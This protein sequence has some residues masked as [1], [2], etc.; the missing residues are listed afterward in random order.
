MVFSNAAARTAAI[1]SPVEGQMTYLEDTDQ[2]A[3]WNG[4][5]W[6]S[7]FGMTL[8][9]TTN[10]TS[11]TT[12]SI[13]NIFSANYS[14]YKISLNIT[15]SSATQRIGMRFRSGGADNTSSNYQYGN[16]FIGAGTSGALGGNNNSLEPSFP[17]IFGGSGG[18]GAVTEITAYNPFTS[19]ITKVTSLG[20]GAYTWSLGGFMTVTTSYDGFTLFPDTGNM[21]GTFKVY[22]MKD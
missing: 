4:S 11:A 6:V 8:L 18:V 16:T 3:S 14:N 1:T 17:I 22:G 20:T 5:A 10:F 13:N 7:P 9:N 12:V 15:S 2:Y 21:T 19:F